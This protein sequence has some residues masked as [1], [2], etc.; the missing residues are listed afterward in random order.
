MQ[1]RLAYPQRRTQLVQAAI[2]LAERDG[3]GS[4][5]IRAV[6]EAAGVSLG[7]V[8]YCFESKEVL[9]SAII[10]S[11][12]AELSDGVKQAFAHVAATDKTSSGCVADFIKSGL[13]SMWEVIKS[14]PQRQILTYEI[15]TYAL[16]HDR[17]EGPAHL[18][19]QQYSI[20]D[21]AASEFFQ[22]V[23]HRFNASWSEPFESICREVLAAID[24]ITLR[25]LVDRNELSATQQFDNLAITISHKIR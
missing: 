11:I 21:Q 25:W 24:G 2:E 12:I 4:L 18:A 14:S 1:E 3:F 9:L 20:M 22:E 16:R 10:E 15:T 13:H 23:A 19:R 17:T 6:A 5:T 8:H 7:V